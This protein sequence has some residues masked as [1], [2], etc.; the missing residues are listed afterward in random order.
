MYFLMILH[1]NRLSD[2]PRQTL[3]TE[4]L[5]YVLSMSVLQNFQAWIPDTGHKM[6]VWFWIRQLGYWNRG[7]RA[8]LNSGSLE[9]A[10]G[11]CLSYSVAYS[12]CS[13]GYSVASR[14][15]DSHVSAG[16]SGK[17]EN[18]QVIYRETERWGKGNKRSVT[19]RETMKDRRRWGG[20]RNGWREREGEWKKE[21][22][23]ERTAVGQ[24]YI[25]IVITSKINAH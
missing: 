2:Q 9:N 16:G 21:I 17:R 4:F 3:M 12:S 24:S 8:W 23:T 6:K 11:L 7:G 20:R 15:G 14:A 13:I 5:I 10:C 22:D 19:E 18:T 1:L 25:A